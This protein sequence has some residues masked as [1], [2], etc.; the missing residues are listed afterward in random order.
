MSE[1][2]STFRLR[3]GDA[4][5]DFSLPHAHGTAVTLEEAMGPKGLLVVFAC[6]HCPFVVHLADALGMLARE[7]REQ[8]IHTVAINSNDTEKYPQDGPEH[9]VEFSRQKKWDFPYL[10][11]ETQ[12]TAMAYGAACTP[13]FFLFDGDGRLFYAGQFDDS[14]PRSGLAAHGGDLRE[15]ARRMLGGEEPLARPYPSSGCNIK[16]KP[17]KQP[18]WWDSGS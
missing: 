7:F 1:V 12:E 16:W 6:N 18:S 13:D 17:G 10:I 3:V 9:M 14:R 2:L 15:S 4:A 5:P 11:D 8:G